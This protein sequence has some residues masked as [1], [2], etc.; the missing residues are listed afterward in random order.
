MYC[1]VGT[2]STSG[3][4]LIVEKRLLIVKLFTI[5]NSKRITYP[6]TVKSV[7]CRRVSVLLDR[8]AQVAA[9]GCADAYQLVIVVYA[10]YLRYGGIGLGK[11]EAA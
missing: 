3:S 2:G 1:A 5:E 7:D 8:Y 11:I 6:Q 4:I 10:L 9:G